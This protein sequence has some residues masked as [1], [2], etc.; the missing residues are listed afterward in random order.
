MGYED[1]GYTMTN[2]QIVFSIIGTLCVLLGLLLGIYKLSQWLPQRNMKKI[3]CVEHD[4]SQIKIHVAKIDIQQVALT[5]NFDK[6]EKHVYAKLDR[7]L[8]LNGDKT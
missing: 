8:K 3:D 7:L 5:K 2:L 4:I 6:F 1:R